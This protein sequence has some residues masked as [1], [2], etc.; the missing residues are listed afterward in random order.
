M[1][2]LV[3]MREALADKAL[4]ADAL[5]GK[6]WAAWRV[7]LIAACGEKLTASERK[8]FRRL[9]ARKREPGCMVETLLVVAG[10]RSGKS[11]ATAVLETYLATCC[12]WSD[13]LS[14][15]ERGLALCIAPSSRQAEVSFGYSAGLIDHVPLLSGLVV[16]RTANV[17]SLQRGID[18]EVQAASP[19]YGRG[20]TAISVR[21]DETAYFRSNDGAATSD[22]ELMIAM[23]PSLSSTAG[24]MILTSSPS[25]MEGV[26]YQLHKRHFGADGDDKIL[27]VQSDSI[28]L[29]PS[30]RKSVIARA[31]ETDP[32]AAASEYGGEFRAGLSNYLERSIVEKCVE[33]GVT[34]RQKLPFITH[35]AFVDVSGGSG[36]NSYTC[37]IGH[38]QKH[39]G[40]DV[41]VI[42]CLFEAKPPLNP[43]ETTKTVAELLRS[44]NVNFVMA[45]SY[46]SQWP[47]SA[48]SKYGI[49]FQA[50]PLT[51]S[52]LYLH[53]L[54]LWVSGRV[55]MIDNVRAVDQLCGLKRK[56]G[57]GGREIIDHPKG[58]HDDLANVVSGVLWRLTPPVPR[59]VI[60]SP[61]IVRG[62][63]VCFGDFGSGY[64]YSGASARNPAHG[65]PQDG[66]DSW[67]RFR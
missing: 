44:Y 12:D 59:Q 13:C 20:M 57:Q 21:L 55:L 1:K 62:S 8:V 45:D 39:Q 19:R 36:Q 11:R 35:M 9:T 41:C 38:L 43:D 65:L 54:P 7:L 47:V 53:S 34:Q 24:M 5:P 23:Q 50:S 3:T 40:Q 2:K 14:I 28:G 22:S 25:Q 63:R 64:G 61:V 52:E 56:L 42:D 10:R 15:G 49:G 37:C 31:Y 16:N 18:I 48:F 51:K 6:S 58:G 32:V 67:G 66:R 4:L 27:V 60:V 26:V 33:P 46:A 30:L 17:L 29:N